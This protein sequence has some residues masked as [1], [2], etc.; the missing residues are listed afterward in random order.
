MASLQIECMDMASTSFLSIC[1]GHRVCGSAATITPVR[2]VPMSCANDLVSFVLQRAD[3]PDRGEAGAPEIVPVQLDQV[4]GPHEHVCIMPAVA[5]TIE[6]GD[7]VGTARNCF[8]RC[9]GPHFLQINS[10][11]T[12]VT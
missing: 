11:A 5:D 7:P 3:G 12:S 2:I 4:E 1:S 8:P 9:G 10:L 6:R